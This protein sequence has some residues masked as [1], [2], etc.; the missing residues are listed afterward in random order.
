M[1]LKTPLTM[2]T[3]KIGPGQLGHPSEERDR[4]A[5]PQQDGE[6][7]R[8]LFAEAQ[9]QGTAANVLEPIRAGDP[10]VAAPPRRQ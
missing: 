4:A 7:A 10:A 2:M 9:A 6:E 3:A 1:K 8:E 5:D